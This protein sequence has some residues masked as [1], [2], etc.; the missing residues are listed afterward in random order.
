[1]KKILNIGFMATFLFLLSYSDASAQRRKDKNTENPQPTEQKDDSQT[2]TPATTNPNK[3]TKKADDY[4]DESGG[5]KHRLW[6]GGNFNLGFSGGQGQSV[7]VI[8]VTP[9]VG[10]KIIGGLSAGPRLGVTYTSYKG[11]DSRG[12][13][14][15]LG[16]T[17]FSAGPF[18]RYKLFK[19]F[20]VQGEHEF[21]RSYEEDASG[22]ILLGSD[23][24]PIR[25][26]R[27]NTY[28]GVG[29]TSGGGLIGYEISLM[30]N[31]TLPSTS[32]KQPFDIR[33]GFNY[34]F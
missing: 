32:F 10:Y 9:M 15:S 21:L 18:V 30:Y 1:M 34:N 7:F 3:K 2:P 22:N 24:K 17:E 5:F 6:Y 8:G 31:F 23:N 26:G 25:Q 16:L 19:N 4:F 11:F 28:G 33:F 12:Y 13:A 27:Q 14:T 29:Y 20:F